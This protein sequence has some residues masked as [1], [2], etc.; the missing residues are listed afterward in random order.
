M[1][2]LSFQRVR[3]SFSVLPKIISQNLAVLVSLYVVNVFFNQLMIYLQEQRMSRKEDL[4]IPL[5]I[6]VAL[7]GF[8]CQS[9]IKAIWI[10][11][12][13]RFFEKKSSLGDFLKK[14]AEQSLIESLR[15]F[16]KAVLWGFLL[17][18][19][20]LVKMIRY[21]FVVFVVALED[22]YEK[23]HVDA[24]KASERLSK[25]HF[26]SL[27]FLLLIFAVIALMTS[28]DELF[29]DAPLQVLIF[30]TINFALLTVESAYLYLLYRDLRKTQ[31]IA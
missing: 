25:N 10:L 30:E 5:M 18:I 21:Q 15:S 14:H 2:V 31:E 12:V 20:G 28:A 11:I 6:G 13:C 7:V 23:G 24:L 27:T 1:Q 9:A 16:F 19:P 26:L 4:Y 29:T 8:L 3:Q 22:R 17:I